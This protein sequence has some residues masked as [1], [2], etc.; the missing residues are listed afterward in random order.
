M[1]RADESRP[2]RWLTPE[3]IIAVAFERS[4]VAM[5]NE[6]HNA[7]RPSVR[8]RIVGRRVL[9]AA[10]DAGARFVAIEALTRP[11]AAQ[12][13]VTRRVPHA[14]DGYLAQPDMRA[15]I[16]DA[17]GLGWTLIA[18]EAD[19]AAKPPG[20]EPMSMYETNWREAAQAQNLVDALARLSND[21]QLL[22]WCGNGHL[23]KAG[24]DDWRPMAHCFR[25][26]SDIEPFA[27]DQLRTVDFDGQAPAAQRWAAA[28]AADLHARGGTAGFLREDAPDGWP[29]VDGADAY[30]LS[31]ENALS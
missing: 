17:L 21:A 7:L 5:M 12:A 8:T 18:Y 6:A 26:A 25:E 24:L 4:R 3:A 22:V 13:N 1:P 30:I 28:Y 27:I 29:L 2:R 15:L 19:F 31:T 14:D 10:H 20:L 16:D 11:F 9:P 23:G